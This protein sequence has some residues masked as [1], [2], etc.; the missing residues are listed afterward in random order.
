MSG[1]CV[2]V[3]STLKVHQTVCGLKYCDVSRIGGPDWLEV[4]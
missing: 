1:T 2:A 3:Q 4:M